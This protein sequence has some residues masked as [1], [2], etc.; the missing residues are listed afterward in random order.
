MSLLEIVLAILVL[1]LA[2]ALRYGIGGKF[3]LNLL[4]TMMGGLP[5][6]IHAFYV[7]SKREVAY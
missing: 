4:L 5:G 3:F 7:L 1:P 2:V 6:I